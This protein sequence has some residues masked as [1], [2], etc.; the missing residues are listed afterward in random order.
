LLILGGIA[1]LVLGF[2][3]AA[4]PHLERELMHIINQVAMAGDDLDL[5][6]KLLQ[7]FIL[8]PTVIFWALAIFAGIMPIIE[9]MIKPLALWLMAGKKLTPQEGFVGGLLCGAGFALLENV[10]YFT[11]ALVAEDWLFMAISRSTTG[12]LHML[13]SGLMGW[14]LARAWR[15]RKWVFLG[16]M[17][18][19]SFLLHGLWNALALAAGI[20]P[21]FVF[22]MEPTFWQT[23]LFYLPLILLL[24]AA[25]AG[26]IGINRYLARKGGESSPAEDSPAD[27][28]P[29]EEAPSASPDPE[30]AS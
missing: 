29:M 24:V 6:I 23:L 16:L 18:L 9:E 28:T 22:G 27:E 19:G 25:V 10:L 1:G 5:A 8:Q 4:N 2:R 30:H 26:L 12:V 3:I 7:P 13:A 14:G 20:A 21:L 17:S 15:D 11:G